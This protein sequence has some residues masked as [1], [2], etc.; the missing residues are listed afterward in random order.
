MMDNDAKMPDL[1]CKA[2]Q[3]EVRVGNSIS[4]RADFLLLERAFRPT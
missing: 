1:T 2:K 3:R 4:G